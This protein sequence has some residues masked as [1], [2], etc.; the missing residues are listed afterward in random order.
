MYGVTLLAFGNGAPDV[1]ASLSAANSA[2]SSGFDLAV[3]GLLG[4]GL[5]ISCVVSGVISIAT[6]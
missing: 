4:S 5:Y 1:F 6:R 2:S 3:A